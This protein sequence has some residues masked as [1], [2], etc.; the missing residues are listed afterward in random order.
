MENAIIFSPFF[1]W[2]LGLWPQQHREYRVWQKKQ[3]QSEEKEQ[4]RKP[5]SRK[6]T[7]KKQKENNTPTTRCFFGDS[8]FDCCCFFFLKSTFSVLHGTIT[9]VFK[10]K[11][12]LGQAQNRRKTWSWGLRGDAAQRGH[13]F[14]YPWE[15]SLGKS[16][17]I[18]LMVVHHYNSDYNY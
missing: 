15:F 16:W 8:V 11:N 18:L 5:N 4:T 17:K 2:S 6:K 9:L 13:P 7:R 14:G 1:S 3:N 10:K 12:T